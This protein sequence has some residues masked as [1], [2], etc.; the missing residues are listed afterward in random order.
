AEQLCDQACDALAPYGAD[1]ECLRQAAR[2]V[3]SRQH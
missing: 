2:F 1:A 3:I